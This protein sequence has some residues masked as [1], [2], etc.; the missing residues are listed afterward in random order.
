MKTLNIESYQQRI[1]EP[2]VIGGRMFDPVAAQAG[3]PVQYHG[4]ILAQSR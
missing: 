4:Q 3:C 1:N 2:F